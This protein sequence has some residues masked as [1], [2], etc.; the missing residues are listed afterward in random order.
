[1]RVGIRVEVSGGEIR[2]KSGVIVGIRV[3]VSGGESRDKS[4][5]EWG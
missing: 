5:G 3:E 2:D 1:M 4:G